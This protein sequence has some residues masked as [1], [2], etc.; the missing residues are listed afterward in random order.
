MFGS[1]GFPEILLILVIALL[2]FG[3]KRLPEVG[4]TIGKGLAEFRRASTDLKRTVSAELALDEDEHT[5][6]PRRPET[7]RS[8]AA[9]AASTAGAR[10]ATE[11]AVEPRAAEGTA[12]RDAGESTGSSEGA[13]DA[14]PETAPSGAAAMEA[15]V[16]PESVPAEAVERDAEAEGEPATTTH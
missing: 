7:G 4:R 10:R 13:P 2:I 8:L 6:A 14:S 5:R 16:E 12:P 15:G 9:G 1:I 3:P 11:D